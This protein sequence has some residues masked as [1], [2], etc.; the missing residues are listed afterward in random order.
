MIAD[1]KTISALLENRSK[2]TPEATAYCM[3]DSDKCWYSI[4]WSK[5]EKNVQQVSKVLI[6]A[7]T[8]KGD[9]V[10]IMAPTSLNWE[11]AQMGALAIS[12]AVAG[13]DPNYPSDQLSHIIRN[14]NLTVL[15]IQDRATLLRIPTE[16]RRQIKLII[17]FA[18]ESQN[19]NE[20]NINDM[21]AA[22]AINEDVHVYSLPEP[23]DVAVIVFSSGTT[24]MPKA[25]VYSHEQVLIAIE[26]ILRV[27]DD[28]KEGTVLLCWLPLANLFQRVVNFCAIRVGATS[29][30]LS[31]PRELMYHIKHVNPDLLIG[32]P[33]VFSRIQL[34]IS[35]RINQSAWLVRILL[36]CALKMSHRRILVSLSSNPSRLLDWVLWRFA[37][38][39]ILSHLRA[40]FGT[41]L[42]YFISGSAPMPLWLLEWYEAIGLPV[43]EAYGVSENIVPIAMNSHSMRKNGTVGKLISPNQVKLT[44]DGEIMVRGPGVFNG[45]LGSL[46]E[47]GERFTADGYWFTND[48]G[49]FDKDGF[50]SLTGRKSDVFKIP[51]GK[52]VSPIRIEERLQRISYVEQSIVFKLD[53]GKMAAIVC[54]DEENLLK[55]IYFLR[56][57]DL[58]DQM[59]ELE[60]RERILRE[61]F[62]AAMQDLPRYQHPIGMIISATRLTIESGELTTN[63]KPRRSVIIELFLPYIRQLEAEIMKIVKCGQL[64][65]SGKLIPVL[66]FA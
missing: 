38:K 32:V 55:K 20:L 57:K 39:L 31:D 12:A 11:Y 3:M 16:L 49:Y 46:A 64:Q 47:R 42:R 48:L 5:F 41:R 24:G 37:D 1:G 60:L 66:L 40:L 54:I 17:F 30:M 35:D 14:L 25:I 23:K 52:W 4:N 13:I 28:L 33:K 51:E 8:K 2:S 36:T 34:G 59:D 15:F 27:F 18:G 21:L 26:S 7:G 58:L 62:D 19:N 61:N 29:Y 10:G 56:E 63:M 65:D 50:L 44:A 43:F 53:S 45:Y 9:H 6:E 22:Q